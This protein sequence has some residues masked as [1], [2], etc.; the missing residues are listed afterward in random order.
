MSKA[1]VQSLCINVGTI[2]ESPMVYKDT[3]I[4]LKLIEDTVEVTN[5]VKP[6]F[7]FKS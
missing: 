3:N 1:G 6:I 5:R 7:N 2:D 4:I